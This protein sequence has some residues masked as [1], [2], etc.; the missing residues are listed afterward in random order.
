MPRGRK[1]K[2]K[3]GNPGIVNRDCAGTGIGR[4]VHHLTVDP[5]RFPEPVR[6]FGGFTGNLLEMA[7]WLS[8]RRVGKVAMEPAPVY[9]IP[10][11]EVLE[12]AGSGVLPGPPGM[13]RRIPGRRSDVLDCQWIRKLLAHGLLRGAF[14]P[15]DHIRPLRPY[16]RRMRRTAGDRPRCVL[17]MRKALTEMNVRLD[18]VISDITGATGLGI[19]RAIVGG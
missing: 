9:W 19:L 10:A 12:R 6:S 8:S 17:H 7:E 15:G 13:R 4:D 5:D 16:V 11:C 3:A 14:R 18:S 1:G 2:G